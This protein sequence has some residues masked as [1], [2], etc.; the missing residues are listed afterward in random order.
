M[1]N[2]LVLASALLILAVVYPLNAQT[3]TCPPVGSVRD[4]RVQAVDCVRSGERWAAQVNGFGPGQLVSIIITSDVGLVSGADRSTR[5]G[6]DGILRVEVDT[7]NWYGA[8]LPPGGYIFFAKDFAGGKGSV[9]REFQVLSATGE[10]APV[11]RPSI[12]ASPA[13]SASPTPGVA[14]P[15]AGSTTS[16]SV[17]LEPTETGT[18]LVAP[19]GT[20]T[21]IGEPTRTATPRPTLP[22]PEVTPTVSPTPTGTATP[23]P[24]PTIT[25]QPGCDP[26]YPGVCIPSPPPELS[27]DEVEFRDFVVL[28][29]DPHGFDSNKDGY[30]CPS[31]SDE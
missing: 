1:L 15:T 30:G 19:T 12:V 16:P 31:E 26:S 25:A 10:V 24:E 2:R 13:P 28:P 6:G 18:L 7:R 5:V 29:P 14:I 20:A 4:P 17:I 8:E 9:R 21:P 3:T 11:V 22:T 23:S 27:C